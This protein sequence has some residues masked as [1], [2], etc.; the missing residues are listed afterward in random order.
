MSVKFE[1][2]TIRNAP[3]PGGI[4]GALPGGIAGGIAG[5]ILGEQG[6]DIAHN[7]GEKLTGGD[8]QTGYLAVSRACSIEENHSVIRR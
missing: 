7:L 8:T 1:K 4:G 5:S 6:K 2:E 3:L